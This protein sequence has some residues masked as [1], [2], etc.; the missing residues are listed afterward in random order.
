MEANSIIYNVFFD[1]DFDGVVMEWEGYA[2]ST[3][4]KEGTELMLSTLVKHK[5][6]KVL[7]NIKKMILIGR[8]D[9][10]WLEID[11]LPRATDLGFKVL[12]IVKPDAYFNRVAAENISYNADQEKL[13]IRFFDEARE[14]MEWLRKV[15]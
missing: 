2:T 13:T 10:R 3:Q 6:H 9:Q 14:A 15:I 8:E 7:A 4:F 11:F 1:Q 12:A 5:A